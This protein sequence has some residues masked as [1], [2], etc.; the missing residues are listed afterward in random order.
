MNI[1]KR[2]YN[3]N[4]AKQEHQ[5]R[6]TCPLYD[7]DFN[8]TLNNLKDHN[9]EILLRNLMEAAGVAPDDLMS[10]C[11]LDK[12]IEDNKER[13]VITELYTRPSED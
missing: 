11:I 1:F 9:K 12:L 7:L 2:L 8:T 6:S 13:G 10:I 3:R 4:K 5:N